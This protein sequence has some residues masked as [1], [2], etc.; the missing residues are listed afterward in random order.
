MSGEYILGFV[1]IIATTILGVLTFRNVRRANST[2]AEKVTV[3]QKQAEFGANLELNK[4]IDGRVNEQVEE[5]M[6]P[7]RNELTNLKANE[8]TRTRAM[9]R[10]LR[11][12][13]AQWPQG[14][15]G[16][17]LDP[18][19]IAAVEETIPTQWLPHAS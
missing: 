7:I 18:D 16:P 8:R 5:R 9:T 19:D 1:S 11:A 17:V 2:A 6:E 3:E 13:A 4:Y 12:I 15:T 14:F 10:I